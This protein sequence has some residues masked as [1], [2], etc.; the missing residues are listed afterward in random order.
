V[1]SEDQNDVYSESSYEET[2][3]VAHDGL[4]QD[5]RK[6][7]VKQLKQRT[8]VTREELQLQRMVLDYQNSNR[9]I[10][11]LEKELNDLKTI[12][13]SKRELQS[14]RNRLTAQISRDRQK[15]EMNFL[16]AQCINYQRLLTKLEK[17]LAANA[18]QGAKG[19]FCRECSGSLKHTLH[20]HRSNMISQNNDTTDYSA[21]EHQQ[22]QILPYKRQKVAGSDLQE[23]VDDSVK[24]TL[25]PSSK[26]RE[27]K[28]RRH[29]LIRGATA[30][31]G[32]GIA[33]VA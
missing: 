33:A 18:Q 25:T 24:T 14:S 26:K 27:T 5:G 21:E 12:N 16:K 32:V 13:I 11:A 30:L 19:T 15:L 17:K 8:H 10:M 29:K 23:S 9:K 20:S 28:A 3:F 1:I 31:L 4:Q 7:E 6:R 22:E 2:I